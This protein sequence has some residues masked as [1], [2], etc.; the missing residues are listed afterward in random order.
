MPAPPTSAPPNSAPVVVVGATGGIGSALAER[1][2]GAGRPLHLVARDPARLGPLAERLGATFA[3]ADVMQGA[4]EL[5][6]AVAAADRGEGIAGLAYCV[7]S[8]LL[9]PMKSTTDEDFLDL[10]RR[11]LLG[12]ARAARAAEAGLRAAGGSVVLFSSVAVA[13][14]FPNHAAVAAAKGAVEGFARALAAEWAPRVRVNA[15]AP[16]LT[17]TPLA[18]GLTGNAA[19]AQAIAQLHP[20]QRLGEP[21][22]AAA[23]A[24]FLLSPEAGWIT[25]QVFGVDGGRSSLR[26][27]G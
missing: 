12:A 6:R 9:K 10:F 18:A 19:M 3:L 4:E 1:L 26:T 2:A 16:S 21:E 11:D 8:I 13:Q 22:D 14:G 15:V 25:G 17:R 7:G 27:K 5:A 23:L 20:M 24:S